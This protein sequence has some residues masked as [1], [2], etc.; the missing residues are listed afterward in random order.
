MQKRSA[1]LSTR[2]FLLLWVIGHGAAWIALMP[3]YDEVVRQVPMNYVNMQSWFFWTTMVTALVPGT[4]IG[5]MQSYLLP[6]VRPM[7][8]AGWFWVSLFGWLLSGFVQYM[9]SQSGASFRL[10][11]YWVLLFLPVAVFQWTLL[12]DKFQSAWLWFLG[13]GV[14]G[15]VFMLVLNMAEFGQRFPFVPLAGVAQGIV[16]GVVMLAVLAKPRLEPVADTY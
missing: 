12:R 14:S 15:V 13:S 5:L 8:V 6:R 16:T 9:Y 7:R 1:F 4:L 11:I 2:L 10:Q 3:V